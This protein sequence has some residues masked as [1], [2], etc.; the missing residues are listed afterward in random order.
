MVV[1]CV[2]ICRSHDEREG[3][4]QRMDLSTVW[5]ARGHME[6]AQAKSLDDRGSVGYLLD[7][8]LADGHYLNHAGWD[9]SQRSCT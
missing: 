4:R 5:P 6:V 7:I 2:Q 1:L 9:C 8:D 3:S